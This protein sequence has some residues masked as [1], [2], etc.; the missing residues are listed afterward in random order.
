[1]NDITL[2]N[3][4]DTRNFNPHDY[5]EMVAEV[6]QVAKDLLQFPMYFRKEIFI[7]YVKDH[8]IKTEWIN[9]NP[10]LANKVISGSLSTENID[11]LFE[12]SRWN[13]SFRLDYESYIKRWLN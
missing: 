8:C 9:A 4:G 10:A 11:K 7:S 6:A 12:G 5:P 3:N 2:S 13:I 1:M